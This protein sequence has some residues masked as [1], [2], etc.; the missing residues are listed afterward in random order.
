MHTAYECNIV[1]LTVTWAAWIIHR[2]ISAEG[3]DHFGRD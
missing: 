2:E 3:P 1:C